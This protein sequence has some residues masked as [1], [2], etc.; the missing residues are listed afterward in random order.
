MEAL[1]AAAGSAFFAQE[2]FPWASSY[3]AL[4]GGY[5]LVT[6]C[7]QPTPRS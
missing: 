6:I 1:P 4:P 5:K 7:L 2:E 3:F